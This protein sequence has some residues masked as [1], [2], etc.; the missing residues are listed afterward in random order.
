MMKIV[1]TWLVV[2][3]KVLRN[4]DFL[5]AVDFP[6][7]YGLVTMAGFHLKGPQTSKSTICDS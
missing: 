5:S 2:A 7:F 3:G 1:L 6:L 4:D